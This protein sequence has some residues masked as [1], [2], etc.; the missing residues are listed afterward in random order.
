MKECE[1]DNP[2]CDG[3]VNECP[4]CLTTYCD[5]HFPSMRVANQQETGLIDVD[6]PICNACGADLT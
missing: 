6:S 3:K 5:V 1:E 2:S 4:L